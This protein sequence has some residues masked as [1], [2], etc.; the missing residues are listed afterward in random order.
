M[1]FIPININQI[2]INAHKLG[3][4]QAIQTSTKLICFENGKV[5]DVLP[6]K[7]KE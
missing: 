4:K 3:V 1:I 7:I 5:T 6:K 2:L